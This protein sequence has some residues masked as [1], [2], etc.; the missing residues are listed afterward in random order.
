MS[1]ESFMNLRNLMIYTG[2]E[3]FPTDVLKQADEK[4]SKVLHDEAIRKAVTRDK[5]ASLGKKLQF[6]STSW[7]QQCPRSKKPTVSVS[8]SSFHQSAA[9]SSSSKASSSSS[10]WGKGKVLSRH[11]SAWLSWGADNLTVGVL[12]DGYRVPFHHLPPVSLVPMEL[13]PSAS[14][15][16]RALALQEEVNKMFLEGAVEQLG[17]G[18]Y[19]CLFLVEKVMGGWRPV[20]DLSSLNNFVTITS[21][22]GS[23][24]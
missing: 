9:K 7:K 11:W 23:V 16:V 20:I 3:L 17:P 24:C 19:S 15:T 1:F 8:G 4:A 10:C 21:V 14:G 5:S 6:S 22:L 13:S 12:G 18:F 2:D